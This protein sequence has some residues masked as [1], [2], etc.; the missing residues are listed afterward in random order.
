MRNSCFSTTFVLTSELASLYLPTYLFVLGAYFRY[1]RPFIHPLSDADLNV[2]CYLDWW[3][4]AHI[5]L[6]FR[7]FRKI[8]F[9]ITYGRTHSS[10][11]C[12]NEKCDE[13]HGWPPSLDCIAMITNSMRSLLHVVCNF[14][15]LYCYLEI[16]ILMAW[17]YVMMAEHRKYFQPPLNKEVRTRLD[18]ELHYNLYFR[19]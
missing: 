10:S 12:I 13:R 9:S 18:E 2:F 17:K 5:S 11:S 1:I 6:Y 15:L 8:R 19:A 3:C 14:S 7:V 16:P 4:F